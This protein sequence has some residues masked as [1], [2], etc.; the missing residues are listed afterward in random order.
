MMLEPMIVILE[1]QDTNRQT[2]TIVRRL[3]DQTA[4][5]KLLL[6]YTRTLE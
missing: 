2:T 1:N 3:D 4:K 6:T 5:P